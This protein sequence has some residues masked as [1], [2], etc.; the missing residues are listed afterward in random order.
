AQAFRREVHRVDEDLPV[1]DVRTLEDRIAENRLTPRLFGAICSVF[2]GIATV[3]AAIGLYAVVAHAVRQRREEIGLRIALRA[4]ARAVSRLLFAQ[5]IKPLAPGLSLG[6]VLAFAPSRALRIALV[7]VSSV[8]PLTFVSVIFVLL[9]AAVLGCI[10][11]AR[12]AM[13]VD[14]VTALS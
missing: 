5:G 11:P 13:R 12:R 6:L 9:L 14:P 8:D 1:Y 10:V 4:S 7:G 2:A 3:L